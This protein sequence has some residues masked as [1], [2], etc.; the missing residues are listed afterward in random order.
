VVFLYV[1]PW[2]QMP[3]YLHQYFPQRQPM[4]VLRAHQNNLKL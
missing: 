1:S 3:C 2:M 4:D